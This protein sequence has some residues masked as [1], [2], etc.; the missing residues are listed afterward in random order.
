MRPITQRWHRPIPSV[1]VGIAAAAVIVAVF[2]QPLHAPDAHYWTVKYGP[3]A[4]LLGGAVIG[5]VNDVSASFYNPGGLAMA[6]S[7]GFAIS[8]SAC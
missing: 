2:V 4:T 1:A 5:S 3:R 6:D 7:L 8:L